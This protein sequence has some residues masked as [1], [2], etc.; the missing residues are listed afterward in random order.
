MARAHSSPLA[1]LCLFALAWS[2]LTQPPS[3][4]TSGP[5][6]SDYSHASMSVT[7]YGSDLSGGSD[8]YWLYLPT[9]PSPDT[10]VLIACFH[11]SGTLPTTVEYGSQ[12][13]EYFWVKH[14]VRKGYVVVYPHAETET[15]II[16]I[17]KDAMTRS[18]QT[19]I[20]LRRDSQNRIR[21]GVMGNS[22]GGL[23][24]FRMAATTAADFYPAEAALPVHAPDWA[25]VSTIPS[26]TKLVQ[27]CGFAD[28]NTST[29]F[30]VQQA[31]WSK[32]QYLPCANRNFIMLRNHRAGNGTTISS[33]HLFPLTGTDS[34]V[35]AQYNV[36]DFYGT[37]KFSEALFNCVFYGTDCDYA[38]GK[39]PNVTNMGLWSN[40]TPYAPAV[41]V[42]SSCF[43][44]VRPRESRADV[45][46]KDAYAQTPH[47]QYDM[48]G[49]QLDCNAGAATGQSHQVRLA[50][51]RDR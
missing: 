47:G 35:T 23:N 36:L 37:W 30:T 18:E 10:S 42:D 11:G 44:S 38:L 49:R 39:G 48:R 34:T 46:P 5:G 51:A 16:A 4:P 40:G 26:T 7:R 13:G 8:V 6:G 15:A 27:L 33:D 22:L 2:Q 3:Q 31:I 9:T 28:N 1:L 41:I 12:I 24:S 25:D 20:R 32:I 17:L 43:V 21:Y 19:G 50:P 45:G 14:L 29:N